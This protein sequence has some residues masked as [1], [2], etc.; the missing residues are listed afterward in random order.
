PGPHHLDRAVARAG[1]AAA[2]PLD[3]PDGELDPDLL[4]VVE[5]GV[6]L[7]VGHGRRPR[8]LVAGRVEVEPEARA[9]PPIAVRAEVRARLG[10]REV[11]VEEDGPK[12]GSARGTP[13]AAGARATAGA[14]AAAA[15]G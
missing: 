5:L 11:D 6:P 15:A 3:D 12:H 8:L 2:H 1:P 9:E 4:V 14:P 10:D 7:Q 13:P